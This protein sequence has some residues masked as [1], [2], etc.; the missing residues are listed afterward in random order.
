VEEKEGGWR[1][2]GRQGAAVE[3]FD[4]AGGDYFGGFGVGGGALR[5]EGR[6]E[7]GRKGFCQVESEGGQ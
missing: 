7:G 6:R 2:G 4:E 1:E 5:R 3:N